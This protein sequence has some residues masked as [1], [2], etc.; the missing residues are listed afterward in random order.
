[1]RA[2][3]GRVACIIY[4]SRYVHKTEEDPND[5]IDWKGPFLGARKILMASYFIG[6]FSVIIKNHLKFELV[7]IIIILLCFYSA[8]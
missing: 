5:I 3:R 6:S 1:M 7:Q 8:V 4:N 2:T